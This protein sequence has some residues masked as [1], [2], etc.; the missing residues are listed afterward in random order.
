MKSGIEAISPY[1]S[2]V[3][4]TVVIFCLLIETRVTVNARH[5]RRAIERVTF[6]EDNAPSSRQK[7]ILGYFE[8][9]G[10]TCTFQPFPT[11]VIASKERHYPR[12][13]SV[14]NNEK[15]NRRVIDK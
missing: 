4:R 7:T 12:I 3:A 5:V 15:F 1:A 9:S 13:T 11:N 8:I 10:E 6:T 2:I 14:L